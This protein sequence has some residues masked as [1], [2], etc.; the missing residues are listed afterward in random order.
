MKA[1][2]QRIGVIGCGT[3]GAAILRG[4]LAAGVARPS[5]LA[6]FDPAAAKRAALKRL[7]A[8]VARS[9]VALVRQRDVVIL[10]VKPQEMAAVAAEIAPALTR[11]H[12]VVSIA[13]GISTRWLGQRLGRGIPIIRVMPNTPAQ[14]R[15]GISV[16][17]RGPSARATHAAI[18]RTIFQALGEVVELPERHFHAVT[19]VSGSGPAYLYMLMETLLAAGR[20]LRLPPAVLRRLVTQTVLGS[21]ALAR[22]AGG[23]PAALRARVTSKG[24]TTEAALK[25][26]DR[27]R[28]RE[29]IVAGV[30]AAARRS[31]ELGR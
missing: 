5:Q 23:A 27:W 2:R 6:G 14:I 3:M 25:V 22:D 29:G 13:A 19:A 16:I 20:Q 9:N 10:A 26:F 17:C 7:H 1:L 31:V 30:V 21:A 28:V 4:L 24:G 12:L 15:Q 11:R 8:R 18:A